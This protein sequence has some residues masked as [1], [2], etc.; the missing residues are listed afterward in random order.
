MPEERDQLIA[1]LEERRVEC[2]TLRQQIAEAHHVLDIFN[3]P[4][5]I[6]DSDKKGLSSLT[7]LGRLR[8]L[9]DRIKEK[10]T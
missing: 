7:L 8:I 3:I 4:R 1:Q 9:Q 2:N 10:V 5:T 6:L